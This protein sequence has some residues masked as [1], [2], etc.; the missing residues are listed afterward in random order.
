MH[1]QFDKRGATVFPLG[2]NVASARG[3]AI[4]GSRY[5]SVNFHAKSARAQTKIGAPEYTETELEAGQRG[6]GANTG[7]CLAATG[8]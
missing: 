6:G 2:G 5:K 8:R 3:A 7:S 1:N 4:L